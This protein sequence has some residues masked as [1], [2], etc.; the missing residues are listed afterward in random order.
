M[1]CGTEPQFIE[2]V[3]E[4]VE[5]ASVGEQPRKAKAPYAPIS[6]ASSPHRLTHPDWPDLTIDLAAIWR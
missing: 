6:A 2:R 5:F 4:S 1:H 3:G